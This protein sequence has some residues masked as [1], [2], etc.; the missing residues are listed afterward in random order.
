MCDQRSLEQITKKVVLAARDCLGEK[1]DKVVLYGSYARG[2]YNSESDIDILVL[3]DI[4]IEDRWKT[5]MQ[6]SKLTYDLDLEHDV[7]VS[8]HVVDRTTFYQY[9]DDLPF[10]INV[11]KDGVELSA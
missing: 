5:R 1:L 3:A 8:L 11:L 6:I 10:Y 4:P 9:A 2:D 7:L